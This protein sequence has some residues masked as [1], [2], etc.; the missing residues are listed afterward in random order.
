MANTT[1]MVETYGQR[2]SVAFSDYISRVEAG[3][4][5][6]VTGEL[7]EAHATNYAFEAAKDITRSI[8]ENSVKLDHKSTRPVEFS[9]A[10]RRID[11]AWS[12]MG[13]SLAK[14][15]SKTFTAALIKMLMDLSAPTEAEL[16]SAEVVGNT[17]MID[18]TTSEYKEILVFLQT[19]I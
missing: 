14:F 15:P 10:K 1:K 7:L 13:N 19:C 12:E 5:K 8:M 17:K 16:V 11:S 18:R 6:N 3:T 4:G 2:L 9:I